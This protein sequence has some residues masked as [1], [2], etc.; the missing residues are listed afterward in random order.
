MANF[1][2]LSEPKIFKTAKEAKVSS[3]LLPVATFVRGGHKNCDVYIITSYDQLYTVPEVQLALQDFVHQGKSII[4]V[5]P[6]VMPAKFY[7][8]D[9]PPAAAASPRPPSPRPPMPSPRRRRHLAEADGQGAGDSDGDTWVG[10]PENATLEERGEAAVRL[11]RRRLADAV[12]ED[13]LAFDSASVTVN[14]ITGPMSLVVSGYVS[15]PG[16][17][18]SVA[19]PSEDSNALLAA[20]QYV[21]FLQG[22]LVLSTTQLSLIV[23]TVSKARAGIS[24][25]IPGSAPLWSLIDAA[26]S[27]AATRPALPPLAFN[28]PPPP[29]RQSPPPLPSPPSPPPRP[30]PF[31]GVL[32]AGV[33]FLGCFADNPSARALATPLILASRTLSVDR[34]ANA[35]LSITTA[36]GGKVT[37]MGMQRS[38]CYGA[39]SLP[40]SF[41]GA[42]LPESACDASCPG[43]PAQKCGGTLSNATTVVTSVYRVL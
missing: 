3:L 29:P 16:G 40:V 8:K 41:F 15:D 2:V 26:D 7:K 42:Q 38:S 5:G 21:Q 43:A 22:K 28:L 1:I 37:I 4:V 23:S 13:N 9:P 35:S 11:Y 31:T 32:P 12:D 34:C 24:R 25:S 17:T 6:D 27:L 36:T 18:S 14:L 33:A 39:G 30:P 19:P 10:W 20:S